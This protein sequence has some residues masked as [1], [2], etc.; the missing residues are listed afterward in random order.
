MM[1]IFQGGAESFER[2]MLCLCMFLTFVLEN[3]FPFVHKSSRFTSHAM[4][5]RLLGVTGADNDGGGGTTG[6][7]GGGGND[8]SSSESSE[9]LSSS[10]SILISASSLKWLFRLFILCSSFAFAMWFLL[11]VFIML[12]IVAILILMPNDVAVL[13]GDVDKF[14]GDFGRLIKS[15]FW[16]I[17][18]LLGAWSGDLSSCDE[19]EDN[20]DGGFLRQTSRCRSIEPGS[21]LGGTR[22]CGGPGYIVTGCSLTIVS[23]N[24]T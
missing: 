14:D 4:L 16:R 19:G 8:V 9:N 5:C 20:S 11:R 23:T 22:F 1:Q 15:S 12:S 24:E 18:P 10:L 21:V 7:G 6:G 17:N 2:K 13:V 3:P